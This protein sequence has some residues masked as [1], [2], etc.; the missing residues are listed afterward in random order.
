MNIGTQTGS[1][2]NHLYSRMTKDAP[3]PEVGMGA[4]ILCW[5]D[6][7]A[8]TVV[9]IE[10][11]IIFVQIDKATRSDNNGMSDVQDYTYE[12]DVEGPVY[13]FRKAKDGKW[14]EVTRNEN[15]GRLNKIERYG[16]IL[17]FRRQYHDY[18]F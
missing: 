4:T 9:K 11:N 14:Q 18:S 17:G 8:A 1:L 7:K 15:T 5:T 2:A 3:E 16:L 10:K 13:T 6:R 12:R